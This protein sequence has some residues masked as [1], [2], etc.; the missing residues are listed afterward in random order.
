VTRPSLDKYPKS[1][2][3]TDHKKTATFV[4][5]CRNYHPSN[6]QF[7]LRSVQQSAGRKAPVRLIILRVLWLARLGAKFCCQFS[8]NPLLVGDSIPNVPSCIART[9]LSLCCSAC[10]CKKYHGTRVRR[11]Y[12]R[13]TSC[14]GEAS[15]MKYRSSCCAV[16]KLRMK[17]HMSCESAMEYSCKIRQ[18]HCPLRNPDSACVLQ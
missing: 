18:R 12:E 10:P 13:H 17:S 6:S 9:N 14:K 8:T 7:S 4:L 15:A 3:G 16:Q 11:C 5:E 1:R 2:S